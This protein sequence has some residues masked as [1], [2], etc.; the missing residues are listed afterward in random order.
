M[1]QK[2]V[3]ITERRFDLFK[4]EADPATEWIFHFPKDEMKLIEKRPIYIFYFQYKYD[5]VDDEREFK[6]QDKIFGDQEFEVFVILISKEDLPN[7]ERFIDREMIGNNEI[8][9][10]YMDFIE[11]EKH[12]K[13]NLFI[14]SLEGTLSALYTDNMDF[15]ARK[16][17]AAQN[18][19]N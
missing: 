6:V 11:S 7:V 2:L 14:F 8:D 19:L 12:Q 5:G 17:L 4:E 10:I 15:F 16:E 3:Y 13:E 9:I 18:T 1:G